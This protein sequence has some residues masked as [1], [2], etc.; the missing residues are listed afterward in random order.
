MSIRSDKPKVDV[1]DAASVLSEAASTD[2]ALGEGSSYCV[3]SPDNPLKRNVVVSIRA[4][5]NDLC[6]SKSKGTWAPSGDALKSICKKSKDQTRHKLYEMPTYTTL[7]A[8]AVQQK[9]F[10]SLDG[11]ADCQGD[12]KSMVLHSLEVTHVSSNFPIG[13]QCLVEPQRLIATSEIVEKITKCALVASVRSAWR[14]RYGR[15]RHHLLLDGR[16]VLDDRR[17]AHLIEP[18]PKFN[19]QTH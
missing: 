7:F 15:R 4:S 12:L 1:N 3:A 6:L 18:A 13:K 5:L 19:E 11:A 14:A 8:F 10:T 2:A 17:D 16:F 9:K